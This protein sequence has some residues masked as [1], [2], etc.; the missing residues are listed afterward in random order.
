MP[1][2]TKGAVRKGYGVMCKICGLNCGKGGSLKAH[3]ELKHHPVTY[4][5]YK[6]CFQS[7]KKLLA[8]AWDDSLSTG[9]QPNGTKHKV[10][11]HTLTRMFLQ[12]PDARPVKTASH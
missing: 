12:A 1:R 11:I 8:D 7:Y 4:G 9:V 5:T 10:V 6:V 3:I 2:R